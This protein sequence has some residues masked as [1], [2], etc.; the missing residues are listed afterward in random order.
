MANIVE[1]YCQCGC[2]QKTKIAKRTKSACGHIKGKPLRFIHGHNSYLRIGQN[3]P[4]YKGGITFIKAKNRWMIKCR[5]GNCVPYS[6]AVMENILDRP[7]KPDEIVHHKNKDSTCDEPWNLMVMNHGEHSTHHNGER[8]VR[9][10]YTKKQLIQK[11]QKFSNSLNGRPLTSTIM[12]KEKDMPTVAT[13]A[14]YFGSWI[15]A[16]KEAGLI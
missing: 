4:N 16:K 11:L 2:G 3:H 9:L 8:E 14:R 7:L 1:G 5:N 15:N 12:L 13:Y 6:H 10:K